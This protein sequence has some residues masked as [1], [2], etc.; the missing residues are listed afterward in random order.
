MAINA[1]PEFSFGKGRNQITV[2]G[3]KIIREIGERLAACC[4]RGPLLLC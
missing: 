1:D 3:E 2:T 4:G